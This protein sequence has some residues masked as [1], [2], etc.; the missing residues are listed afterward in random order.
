MIFLGIQRVLFQCFVRVAA[1]SVCIEKHVFHLFLRR[2]MM[3][4]AGVLLLLACFFE[5]LSCLE[6]EIDSYG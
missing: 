2:F 3:V 6:Q 1:V 5:C 4:N